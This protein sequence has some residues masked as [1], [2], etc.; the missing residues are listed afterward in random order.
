[1]DENG[2]LL[3]LAALRPGY[4][5]LVACSTTRSSFPILRHLILE[6][7][8]QSLDTHSQ[9]RSRT[10]QLS[11]KAFLTSLLTAATHRSHSQQCPKQ[12]PSATPSSL[13][14]VNLTPSSP[15][16]DHYRQRDH[17]KNKLDDDIPTIFPQKSGSKSLSIPYKPSRIAVMQ[18]MRVAVGR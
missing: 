2:V 18:K 5:T 11:S 13:P 16:F 9:V 10:K 7:A 8:R 14:P 15:S 17:P 12:T 6:L 4:N 3:R 1:M